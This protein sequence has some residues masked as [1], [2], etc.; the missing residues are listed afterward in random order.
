M[1]LCV[2]EFL[3]SSV[4][5]LARLVIGRSWPKPVH[6]Q[7]VMGSMTFF[8]EALCRA[9]PRGSPS[10]GGAAAVYILDRNQPSL[11]TPFY[12]VLVPVSVSMTLST[13]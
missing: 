4:V 3:V 7:R 12:S 8:Y 5:E 2:V 9:A 11:P 13:V 1:F 10:R 6:E